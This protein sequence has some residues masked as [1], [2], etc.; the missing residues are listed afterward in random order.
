VPNSVSSTADNTVILCSFH[1]ERKIALALGSVAAG[2]WMRRTGKYYWLT[3]SMA[4]SALLSMSVIATF[5]T[6]TPQWLLWV[7]I[8]PSGFGMSGVITS[9]LI[10]L[11]ACVRKEDIA[12]AT[13]GT[14]EALLGDDALTLKGWLSTV[15]Y[16]FRTTGYAF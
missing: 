3:I 10:A 1:S 9:T 13:G 15:S 16:M 14:C 5:S 7:A 12:V 8:V 6:H 4:A 2:A 11:I